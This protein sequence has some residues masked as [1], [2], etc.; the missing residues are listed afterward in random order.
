[1]HLTRKQEIA[2]L[3]DLLNLL[4]MKRACRIDRLAPLHKDGL[5]RAYLSLRRRLRGKPRK[6][7]APSLREG[8]K[9]MGYSLCGFGIAAMMR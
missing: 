9:G 1:M 2:P 6:T 3:K 8:V 5:Y 4:K 7:I